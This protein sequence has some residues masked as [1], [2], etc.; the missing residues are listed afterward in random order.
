MC[1]IGPAGNKSNHAIRDEYID[2]SIADV[3]SILNQG[4]EGDRGVGPIFIG[5]VFVAFE[6][7]RIQLMHREMFVADIHRQFAVDDKNVFA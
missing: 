3:R 5:M 7:K 4:Q 6:I 2:P 1:K